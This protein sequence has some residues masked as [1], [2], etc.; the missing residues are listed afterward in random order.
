MTIGEFSKFQ[1][2]YRPD[3]FSKRPGSDWSLKSVEKLLGGQPVTGY[4]E[5]L[6]LAVHSSFEGG[7]IRFLLPGQSSLPSLSSW[8]SAAGWA[9]HWSRYKKRLIV[10]AYDWLGRQIA[11]DHKRTISDELLIAILEPGTGELLEVPTTFKEFMAEELVEYHEAALASSFYQKWRARG[12]SIPEP[13]QCIGYKIPLFLGG[14]DTLNNL[15]LIDMEVYVTI[16][17]A[18]FE[19]TLSLRPGQKISDVSISSS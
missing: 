1:N 15:E 11:F 18:L 8:N 10:F 6:R 17:G 19:Q 3:G 12:G 5:F 13:G 16:C 9:S 7:L 2:C 4:S 14:P